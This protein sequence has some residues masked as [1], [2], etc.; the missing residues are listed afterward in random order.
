MQ[1]ASEQVKLGQSVHVQRQALRSKTEN[2]D[3]QA[4]TALAALQ[5]AEEKLMDA[6]SAADQA[7][8]EGGNMQHPGGH[9]LINKHSGMSFHSPQQADLEAAFKDVVHDYQHPVFTGMPSTCMVHTLS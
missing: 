8:E 6:E 4:S 2:L 7:K 1:Q 5:A 9:L 3:Q